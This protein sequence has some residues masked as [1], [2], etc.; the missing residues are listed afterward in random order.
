MFVLLSIIILQYPIK[1]SQ[2]YNLMTVFFS[3]GHLGAEPARPIYI[4]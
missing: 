3:S 1:I 2:E 4:K